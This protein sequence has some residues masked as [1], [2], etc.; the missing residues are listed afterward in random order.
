VILKFGHEVFHES[1]NQPAVGLGPGGLLG[2]LTAVP[3]H[4]AP[5]LA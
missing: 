5:R 3:N 4:G 2:E 1:P